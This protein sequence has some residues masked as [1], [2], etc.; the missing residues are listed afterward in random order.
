MRRTP[1][2]V[3][4]LLTPREQEILRLIIEGLSNKEIAQKLTVTLSTVKWYVKQI[5]DKLASAAGCRRW[6]GRANSICW[7]KPA[8]MPSRPSPYRPKT[9]NPDKPYKG[10]RAFQSADYQ[11]FFGREKVIRSTGVSGWAKQANLRA[12]LAV[13]GPSGSGKSS[14]VKAGLIPAIWRGELPGSEKWFVAEMLPGDHPLD[15]LEIALMRVAANQ[16]RNV[17][18]QLERDQRGLLRAAQLILPNDGSELVVVIDQFEEVFTLLT[19]E[20]ARMHF[21][22]LLH[23]AVSEPRSRVRVVITLRADFYDRPL[24]YPDFGE[25]VRSRMETVLPLSADELESA[26]VRTG[27]TGWA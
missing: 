7:S 6:C 26:I 4:E 25:L 1:T 18:E 19:E 9:F 22:S 10:L 17:R 20:D 24:Q 8:T 11:D 14:L 27:R 12:F 23:T 15:E 3:V 16:A 21:L 13:V 2:N 5:Y